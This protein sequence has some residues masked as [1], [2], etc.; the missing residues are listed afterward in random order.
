M[1]LL[2]QIITTL[3]FLPKDTTKAMNAIIKTEYEHLKALL[4]IKA[5]L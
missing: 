3:H 5:R 1:T 2:K 4:S